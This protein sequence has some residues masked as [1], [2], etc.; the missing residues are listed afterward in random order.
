M[1]KKKKREITV[2]TS[3]AILSI[4]YLTSNERN[5]RRRKIAHSRYEYVTQLLPIKRRYDAS[6]QITRS[7]KG[8]INRIKN[9]LK[10]RIKDL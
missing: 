5:I 6:R 2:L 4:V 10:N 1:I 3:Q 7:K 8:K 9:K